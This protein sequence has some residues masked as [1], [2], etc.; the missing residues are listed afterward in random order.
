[1]RGVVVAVV[2]GAVTVGGVVVVDVLIVDD[3]APPVVVVLAPCV[4]TLWSFRVAT[5]SAATMMAMA[6]PPP[7]A[8][9]RCGVM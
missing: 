3:G 5:T 6:M 8:T 1:V 2:V 4:I 7:N 9:R